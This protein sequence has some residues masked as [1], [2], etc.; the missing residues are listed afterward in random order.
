MPGRRGLFSIF[1]SRMLCLC[2]RIVLVCGGRIDDRGA[3]VAIAGGDEGGGEI[4]AQQ[5]DVGGM[6]AVGDGKRTARGGCIVE[7][8]RLEGGKID[9]GQIEDVVRCHSGDRAGEA[10]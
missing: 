5:C 8:G 10:G 2:E 9:V 1:H 7:A 6:A 4:V 3:A